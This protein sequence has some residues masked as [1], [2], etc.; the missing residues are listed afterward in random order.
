MENSVADPLD[1][2][3]VSLSPRARISVVADPAPTQQQRPRPAQVFLTPDDLSQ[4]KFRYEQQGLGSAWYGFSL[5]GSA[6]AY[7]P[8]VIAFTNFGD[9]D[10]VLIVRNR[11]GA[12]ALT[13]GDNTV[14]ATSDTISDILDLFDEHAQ[15]R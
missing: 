12:Y 11:D 5:I 8:A 4:V 3:V 7:V 9:R 1:Q 14:L 2:N 6:P 13:G 15:P 10:H